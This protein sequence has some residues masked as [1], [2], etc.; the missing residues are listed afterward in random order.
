MSAEP[1]AT[2]GAVL[3][4]FPLLGE[5]LYD[6]GSETPRYYGLEDEVLRALTEITNAR[7]GAVSATQATP[8]ERAVIEAAKAWHAADT[9]MRAMEAATEALMAAVDALAAGAV[10]ELGQTPP[11]DGET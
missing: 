3:A 5:L 2:S 11:R 9:T 4:D 1:F 10:D 8:A 6:D 7:R